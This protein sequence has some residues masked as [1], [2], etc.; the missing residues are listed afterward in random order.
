[1]REWSKLDLLMY[2]LKITQGVDYKPETP[3]FGCGFVY[4]T[5]NTVVP[6]RVLQQAGR[7]RQL[8]ENPFANCPVTFFSFGAKV[9]RPHLPQ[10]GLGRI[11]AF[12]DEQEYF[13]DFV[14][15][16]YG[17]KC[18][19]V[20]YE[21]SPMWREIYLLLANERETFLHYPLASYH[22]W[23]R[24]DGYEITFDQRRRPKVNWSLIETK[25]AVV[26]KYEDIRHISQ[27][28]YETHTGPR[29]PEILKYEF[30]NFAFRMTP[31][32]EPDIWEFYINNR[33][34]VRNV[35]YEKFADIQELVFQ[36][37]DSKSPLS[38]ETGEWAKM[39]PCKLHIIK[40]LA[41]AF[42]L[43][44]FW[45]N[46]KAEITY[47]QWERAR[48]YVSANEQTICVTWKVQRPKTK[49]WIATLLK[50]CLS[51]WGNYKLKTKSRRV[52]RVRPVCPLSPRYTLAEWTVLLD[53][54]STI[55][56]KFYE[57]YPQNLLVAKNVK[58][59]VSSF[60][61]NWKRENPP[62]K[63]PKTTRELLTGPYKQLLYEK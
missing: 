34:Q 40:E 60:R 20:R 3:H 16:H 1:M 14:S 23:L 62:L 13:L 53:S 27:F 43:D 32:E 37:Y 50:M 19:M 48:S 31:E 7:V 25:K 52:D 11:R 9:C 59:F 36:T 51:R 35:R 6:R 22:W 41:T 29:T 24:H 15:K 26:L 38:Q 49:D 17:G 56:K 42:G 8:G 18:A 47:A 10:C 28:E 61:K 12:A 58:A 2:T 55:K 4:S 44:C 57:S 46:D 63:V 39:L 33:G 21:P 5:P 54:N 45:N 30:R